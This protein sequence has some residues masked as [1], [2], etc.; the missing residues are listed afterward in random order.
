MT[1]GHH[2]VRG[3]AR[4]NSLN[5]IRLALAATVLVSHA[6]ITYGHDEP[7]LVGRSGGT[8]AV[9]GFFIISGYLITR[10]RER[11]SLSTFLLHRVARLYP[12]YWLCLIVTALLAV[13]V[14]PLPDTARAALGYVLR[15][16]T[17]VQGQGGIASTLS[18]VPHPDVWNASL[19]TLP[20]EMACYLIV[21]CLGPVLRR[22]RRTGVIV[23]WLV[24][25]AMYAL[26]PKVIPNAPL[27]ARQFTMLLTFFAAGAAVHALPSSALRPT[28]RGRF[29][30]LL[31]IGLTAFCLLTA[32]NGRLGPSIGAPLLG[33]A[34]LALS[35]RWPGPA[36][37]Q[38]HDISY[39]VYV[40]A[41]P[42]SQVL[43]LMFW[44]SL[45]FW[46][47]LALV[48][49]LTTGAAVC[50]WLLVERRALSAAKSYTSARARTRGSRFAS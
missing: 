25:L 5:L 43:A 47:Y 50:S 49:V 29:W 44:P 36:L 33:A 19:W 8:W 17:L 38:T 10:S 21:A 41:F 35:A 46:C 16:F 39:G 12:A 42:M 7:A 48:G 18:S 4:A 23:F 34:L 40:Y 30:A 9:I 13:A 26:L 24:S 11:L 3:A 22:S 15:N 14:Q 31:V 37:P 45:P 6:L 20:H 27:F 32:F 2:E 1:A 28:S